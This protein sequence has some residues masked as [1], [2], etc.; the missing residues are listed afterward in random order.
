[1]A[2]A[3][4]AHAGSREQCIAASEKA[5][6]LRNAGKLTEARVELAACGRAE[7]PKLVRHDCAQW[8]TEVLE[9]LPSIVL[10]AHDRDGRDL[11]D[12]KVSI[13]GEPAAEAL[14]GKPISVD[15]GVH[16]LRFEAAGEEL[17][18][19]R[20]VVKQGE[21]N[22]IVSVTIGEAPGEPA[23]KDLAPAGDRREAPSS[24]PPVAAFVVGGIGLAA[25]GAGAY[26]GLSSNADADR[27]KSECAPRCDPADVD[28]IEE[29]RVIAGVTAAAGGALVI[30]AVVLY[31]VHQSDK[32]P[33][34]AIAPLPGGAAGAA[35]V[36]F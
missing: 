6:E 30:A 14:D 1:M 3:T 5:Q 2:L 7:C 34:V 16:V 29:R 33:A 22:R 9:M 23:P 28:A 17:V 36:R 18:E 21:K 13:D 31:F 20:I 19:E 4:D 10:G 25:L 32:T 12:V 26:L 24:S 35:V 8:M 15:P 27:L 11:V